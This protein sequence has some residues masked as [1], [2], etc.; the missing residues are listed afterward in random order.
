MAK[1][2][3]SLSTL[4]PLLALLAQQRAA[5][6]AGAPSTRT[7][8]TTSLGDFDR[9]AVLKAAEKL[10]TPAI[11]YMTVKYDGS[12]VNTE[13]S[14]A[15][16]QWLFARSR[17]LL[18]LNFWG[19]MKMYSF[20]M[21]TSP[22]AFLT[23]TLDNGDCIKNLPT[24]SQRINETA[25]LLVERI[26]KEI[27]DEDLSDRRHDSIVLCRGINFPTF[28]YSYFQKDCGLLSPLRCCTFSPDFEL[29]GC[30]EEVGE[31][32]IWVRSHIF[33]VIIGFL[34]AALVLSF[35]AKKWIGGGSHNID[36]LHH[37][38][39]VELHLFVLW[40]N[41]SFMCIKKKFTPYLFYNPE[42]PMDCCAV[43]FSCCDDEEQNS[44]GASPFADIGAGPTSQRKIPRGYVCNKCLEREFHIF[45][46]YSVCAFLALSCGAIP[47]SNYLIS[48]ELQG[49]F[50]LCDATME[51][52]FNAWGG[53][54]IAGISA[55]LLILTLFSCTPCANRP[56]EE[57]PNWSYSRKGS[58]I[59]LE[60]RSASPSPEGTLGHSRTSTSTI[61]STTPV[62]HEQPSLAGAVVH[63]PS[64][65]VAVVRRALFGKPP[66][67]VVKELLVL[68]LVLGSGVIVCRT[69]VLMIRSVIQSLALFPV[70][71]LAELGVILGVLASIANQYYVLLKPTK[72]IRDMMAIFSPDHKYH[73][74]AV[75]PTDV[76]A[77]VANGGLKCDCAE[78]QFADLARHFLY[79]SKRHRAQ[80]DDDKDR[81]VRGPDMCD[82]N[83]WSS[84]CMS[85]ACCPPKVHP[86][87]SSSA[88]PPRQ[89]FCTWLWQR[90][91]VKKF[92]DVISETSKVG[93]LGFLL[94][95][96]LY[97][98][99]NDK[100]VPSVI[101][102]II[103]FIATRLFSLQ[104]FKI[105]SSFSSSTVQVF[106]HE[107]AKYFLLVIKKGLDEN[108]ELEKMTNKQCCVYSKRE[109]NLNDIVEL[110]F[111][112]FSD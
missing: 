46:K 69:F 41:F 72:A 45:V 26:I 17:Q 32:N 54:I 104:I 100:V 36:D 19:D 10:V 93:L 67:L 76:E 48:H 94:F 47:L 106:E 110:I 8:N 83:C 102:G 33:D 81:A 96:V 2:L 68:F 63:R 7:C 14:A 91:H 62:L 78:P 4:L 49:P 12:W 21:L 88:L 3:L 84:G 74:T 50:S 1:A 90:K 86:G 56:Y 16:D 18:N 43:Q 27:R 42:R 31:S 89:P 24:Q 55:I 37:R 52:S 71:S 70:S 34:V 103:T 97:F 107:Y 66:I 95:S 51:L 73:L 9:D 111:T 112:G 92:F 5:W 23:L 11:I 15:E 108:R 60:I 25:A 82:A 53:A 101:K 77:G 39:L 20:D 58:D 30:D 44:R 59:P 99:T 65:P 109:A 105:V 80:D 85:R 22:S 6:A 57:D 64:N 29:L 13:A 98:Q 38:T 28:E 40:R 35:I 75:H 61:T 79:G 87:A